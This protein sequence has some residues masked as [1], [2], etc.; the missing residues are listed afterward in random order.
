MFA[1]LF[2]SLFTLVLGQNTGTTG[3]VPPFPITQPITQPLPPNQTLIMTSLNLPAQGNYSIGYLPPAM[4]GLSNSSACRIVSMFKF[5]A[6]MTGTA[7]TMTLN[8]L[9][10]SIA[11]TCDIGFTLF[12]FSTAKQVGT[13]FLGSF[14]NQP[15]MA[16]EEPITL[17]V[18]SAG[19]S[20]L[21]N[22]IYYLRIQTFTWNTAGTRCLMRLP[23]GLQTTS[24]A[25]PAGGSAGGAAPKFA[26]VVQQG[27]ANLPCGA[28]PFTTVAA[29]DGGYI[30]MRMTAMTIISLP[31]PSPSATT[32]PVVRGLSST[33]TNSPT[34][35]PTGTPTGSGSA[36][37]TKSPVNSLSRTSTSNSLISATV[38]SIPGQQI[39]AN[40]QAA[41]T[42]PTA[43]SPSNLG[44]IIGTTLGVIIIIVLA[45]LVLKGRLTGVKG[46][47]LAR[48]P[49]TSQ[50]MVVSNPSFTS[51][52]ALNEIQTYSH[53]T[54]NQ[55][56]QV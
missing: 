12:D 28:T 7:Q 39:G 29:L 1:A 30:H 34:S 55:G 21:N 53:P 23:W 5:P 35:T 36:S 56:S 15:I 38:T 42:S 41:L 46:V 44:A 50:T 51:G 45:S 40:Q 2:L 8:A 18:S 19:W 10:E 37:N 47:G 33:I 25:P 16:L 4:I 3:P 48:S 31:S 13:E 9:P 22:S 17:D 52:F 32:T 26:V 54:H 49:V 6:L 14:T 27:P 11:E 20:M 43:L 24:A